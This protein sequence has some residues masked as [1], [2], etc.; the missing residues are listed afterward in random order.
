M[1]DNMMKLGTPAH[2][3]HR[4]GAP[5][6]SVDAA[7]SVNSADLEGMVLADVASF[8]ILGCIQDDV[9]AKHPGKPYSSITAR[10]AAL[11]KKGLI[12]DTGTRRAGNSGRKQRVLCAS[13]WRQHHGNK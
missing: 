1:D 5:D 6:T 3:L 7:Q 11:I 9:I 10:F 13:N 4:A 12:Y 2:M 8:G